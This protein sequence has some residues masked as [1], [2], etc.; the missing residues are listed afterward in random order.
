[1]SLEAEDPAAAPADE[2]PPPP[3]YESVANLP[4]VRAAAVASRFA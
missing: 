2:P 4:E 1:M 3:P